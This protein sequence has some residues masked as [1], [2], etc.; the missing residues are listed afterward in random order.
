MLLSQESFQV[1]GIHSR[2]THNVDFF[3]LHLPWNSPNLDLRILCPHSRTFYGDWSRISQHTFLQQWFPHPQSFPV[4]HRLGVHLSLTESPSGRRM[5]WISSLKV[6]VGNVTSL[7]L[8]SAV[9]FVTLGDGTFTFTGIFC[10]NEIVI[11][12][13]VK[14]EK[15]IEL[16]SL[17]RIWILR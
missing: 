12:V 11:S 5:H 6:I 9:W 14:H 17:Q 4:V 1:L 8:F 16:I 3:S 10:T 7:S 2:G 15:L 13:P